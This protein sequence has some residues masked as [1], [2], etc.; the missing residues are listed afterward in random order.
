MIQVRD[1]D[2]AKLG[3]LFERYHLRLF[4]FLSRVTGDRSAAE[5]LVQ[6]VFV[7][8]LKYRS[9]YRDDGV[10]ETWL[11]RIARNAKADHF[12]ARSRVEPLVGEA[13]DQ[14]EPAPGPVAQL[15]SGRD[16]VRLN[17]ALMRLREDKRELIV[18]ARYHGMTHKQIAELLEIDAGAVTVRLHR[19]L[20]E[21]REIFRTTPDG[22]DPCAA[23]TSG[24][25]LQVI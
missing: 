11:F 3:L 21:L 15:E 23:K 5:D 1:G 9:T 10:F 25:I 6:D 13:S 19:A 17:R 8:V 16:L 18:L 2:L 7:R 12:R 20:R 24:P 22:K 4:N 14:A